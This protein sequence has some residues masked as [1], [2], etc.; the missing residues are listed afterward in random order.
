MTANMTI[1]TPP[2][3]DAAIISQGAKLRYSSRRNLKK[4]SYTPTLAVR[5][6][7]LVIG[8]FCLRDYN[9]VGVKRNSKS[10]NFRTDTHF[11][12]DYFFVQKKAKN[13]STA[14]K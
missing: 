14:K 2:M 10:L 6:S 8:L 5:R 13:K 12:D 9:S 11:D 7:L 1:F 3:R 4:I